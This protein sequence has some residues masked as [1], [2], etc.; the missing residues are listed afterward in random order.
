VPCPTT[1]C[2]RRWALLESPIVFKAHRLGVSLNSRLESNKEEEE[3][4]MLHHQDPVF[5]LL[6]YLIQGSLVHV[7]GFRSWALVQKPGF[8]WCRIQ[9]SFGAGSR[10]W[11]RIQGSL[12][13]DPGCRDLR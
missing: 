1:T 6:W 11:C 8:I 9:G 12:V 3:P 7:P 2:V 10:L 5:I 13:Q 4:W